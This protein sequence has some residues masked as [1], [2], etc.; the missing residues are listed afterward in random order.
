MGVIGRLIEEQVVDDDQ[1]HRGK[2]RCHMVRVG[3]GLEDILA[4]NIDGAERA[5]HRRVEHVGDAQARFRIQHSAPFRLEHGAGGGIG[6][7][8]IARQ[9]VREAAH[10]A[11][12]LHVVLP[13][14]RV[15]PHP[16][17]A[18]IAGGHGQIGNGHHR[19]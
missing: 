6:N 5:I 16:R 2:T 14:Q 18:D 1:F 3:V 15:H 12:P 11:G 7:M 4:L 13:P 9:L 17:P 10:V 8:P 19:G